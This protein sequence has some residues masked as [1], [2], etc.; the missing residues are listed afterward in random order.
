MLRYS[1]VSPLPKT[2]QARH[3]RRREMNSN[4]HP[5]VAA[6]VIVLSLVA[7]GVW[8]WG[9]GEAARI[10]GPAELR[11][12]PDGHLYIQIRNQLV[13]HNAHGAYVTTHDLADL[14]VELV[15][16]SFAFFSNGDILLRRGPDPRSFIDNV[17]AFQRKT[18]RE[19]LEPDTPETG[20]YRCDL[21]EATCRPFGATPV[22][23][24]AAHSIFIDWETDEVYVADTTRH[25]LRKYSAKGDVLAAP[26]GG[27]RF[28][29]Q[30]VIDA[31]QLLVA[32]TNHHAI[33]VV[34][35]RTAA[36]GHDRGRHDVVPAAARAARQRW[37][38][39]FARVGDEWWVNN[40][41]TGMNEGGI[42]VFD[43]EWRYLRRV[44]LPPQADPISLIAF[45]DGVLVSDWNNDVVYR[46]SP[47]GGLF[48]DFESAG[49]QQI[50]LDSQAARRA[51]DT[52]KYLGVTLFAFVFGGLLVRAL[53]VSLSANRR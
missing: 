19:S 2:R 32:D 17:R 46:L 37:P 8:I 36:F 35:A 39:H 10:G 47:A 9:S 38:S 21:D 5:A 51:F 48:P 28:P 25:L 43:A 52:Y 11:T 53:A 1:T 50:V 15:L 22:D 27:F 16:G 18:N 49:L 29:N 12:D 3:E 31:G 14:G 6:L 23:F 41:R 40:M 20:L 24:K 7:V 44:A 13:E 26:V 33:R 34:D 4:V 30:L 42:Y 45:N